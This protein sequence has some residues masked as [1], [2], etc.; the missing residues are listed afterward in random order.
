MTRSDNNQNNLRILAVDP[1]GTGTSGIYYR[2]GEQEQFFQYWDQDWKKHQLFIFSLLEKYIPNVLLYEHT[3][4]INSRGKDMTALLSLMGALEV[5]LSRVEK[6]LV[7]QV[8][9]LRKELLKGTKTI[10]NLTYL[11]GKGW[12]HNKQKISVHELDAYLVYWLWENKA[13]EQQKTKLASKTIEADK[14]KAKNK[15]HINETN[16][17]PN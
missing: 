7:A 6:I 9:K 15:R 4:F 2:N 11:T 3:N 12:H 1:S 13:K 10:P 16:Y 8:K 5:S 14:S 17:E